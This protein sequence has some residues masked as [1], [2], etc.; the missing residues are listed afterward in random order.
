MVE[1]LLQEIEELIGTDELEYELDG[2]M[3]QIEQEGAGLEL[4]TPILQIMER[5]PLDDFG[6]PGAMVHF[7]EQFFGHGYEEKLVESLKRR[8]ASHT[9][10]MLNRI[11]NGSEN[12]QEYM[13]L[14]KD[15]AGREDLEPEIRERAQEYIEFQENQ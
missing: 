7:V 8:P 4:V 14:L 9:V 3:I 1:Q 2:K 5:H 15:I 13:E 6:V 10:W 12:I 11:I